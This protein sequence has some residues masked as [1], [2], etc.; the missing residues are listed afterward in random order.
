MN[1]GM[2]EWLSTVCQ[3]HCRWYNKWQLLLAFSIWHPWDLLTAFVMQQSTLPLKPPLI[4]WLVLTLNVSGSLLCPGS[5]N[6]TV[7]TSG[8]RCGYRT[9]TPS[10]SSGMLYQVSGIHG[11]KHLCPEFGDFRLQAEVISVS[12][13]HTGSELLVHWQEVVFS[14][15]KF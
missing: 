6:L 8:Q 13:T 1:E 11:S 5:L 14:M 12:I 7:C 4:R 3:V 9:K 10:I 15:A 2:N